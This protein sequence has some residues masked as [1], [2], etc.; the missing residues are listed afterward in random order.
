MTRLL[1]SKC[2]TGEEEGVVLDAAEEDAG[3]L[4]SVR[5]Q[6]A[7]LRHLKDQFTDRAEEVTETVP[8]HL[9]YHNYLEFFS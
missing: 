3:P 4:D 5:D 2:A 8:E 1:L 6:E 9:F 7:A